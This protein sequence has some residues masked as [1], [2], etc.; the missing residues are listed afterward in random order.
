[1]SVGTVLHLL[2]CNRHGNG[3][4]GISFLGEATSTNMLKTWKRYPW[5]NRQTLCLSPFDLCVTCSRGVDPTPVPIHD[6]TDD[7]ADPNTVDGSSGLCLHADCPLLVSSES[8]CQPDD[9]LRTY[10]AS[11]GNFRLG[12]SPNILREAVP[13]SCCP[14]VCIPPDTARFCIMYY[15]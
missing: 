13:S 2:L 14:S 7:P 5:I 6:S 12:E 15:H 10:G 3:Q 9:L 11:N 8:P 1:M 4:R